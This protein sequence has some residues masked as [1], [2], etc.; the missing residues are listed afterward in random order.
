MKMRNIWIIGLFVAGLLLFGWVEGAAIPHMKAQEDQYNHEQLS[1]LTHDIKRTEK[2]RTKFMGSFPHVAGVFSSLPLGPIKTYQ[3]DSDALTVQLNMEG[4]YSTKNQQ[5]EKTRLIYSA[6]AAFRYI[7]NLEAIIY[8]FED[9][10]YKVTRSDVEKW[11]GA[12]WDAL[13]DNQTVW[14]KEVQSKLADE[15]YV[16]KAMDSLFHLAKPL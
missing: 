5:Q 14:K 6:T 12:V 2:S 8:H 4:S 1:P 7:D 15:S 3:L 9:V 13:D 16:S 11:Y 10:T